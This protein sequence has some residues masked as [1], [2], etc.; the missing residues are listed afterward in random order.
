[1]LNV[2][3][4]EDKNFKLNLDLA[5]KNF[6]VASSDVNPGASFTKPP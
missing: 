4:F 6:D 2:C 1:M 3:R 5:K